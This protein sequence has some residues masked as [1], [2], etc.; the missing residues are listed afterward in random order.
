MTGPGR[1]A[2]VRDELREPAM[3]T[4]A[5]GDR[6]RLDQTTALTDDEG[7]RVPPFDAVAFALSDLWA[8]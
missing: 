1:S 4:H 7:V 5:R 2:I 3:N 8:D 6:R